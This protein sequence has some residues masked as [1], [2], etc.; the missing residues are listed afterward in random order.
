MADDELEQELRRSWRRRSVIV[1]RVID[2]APENATK[3]EISEQ[4]RQLIRRYGFDPDRPWL[5]RG[6]QEDD[7]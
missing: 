5:G 1:A 4:A 6:Q 3:Q 2:Q 7:L